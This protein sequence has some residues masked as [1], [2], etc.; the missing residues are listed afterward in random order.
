MKVNDK[1]PNEVERAHYKN[2]SQKSPISNLTEAGESSESQP[3]M[4]ER[5]IRRETKKAMQHV[6]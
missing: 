3:A 4:V 1:E 6:G 2:K 5:T